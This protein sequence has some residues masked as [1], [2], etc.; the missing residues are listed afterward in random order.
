M[1]EQ[2]KK[3]RNSILGRL[4]RQ[5]EEQKHKELCMKYGKAAFYPIR[6]LDE[7]IILYG[8]GKLGQDLY[9]RLIE[10]GMHEIV[11]W[12]D[13]NAKT[14]RQQGMTKVSPVSEIKKVSYDKIVIAVMNKEVADT[15]QKELETQG[16]ERDDMIWIQTY[17]YPDAQ[18]RWQ[19]EK[20]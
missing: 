14:Y 13:K 10:E 9:Y 1:I 12:V 8:A 2:Y 5:D 20:I 6:L 19:A 11:L 7:Q 3:E 18:I 17:Q 4:R 15:I 16:I